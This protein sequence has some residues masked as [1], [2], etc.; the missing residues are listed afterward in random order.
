MRKIA[1]VL[2]SITL[3]SFS[4]GERISK[5]SVVKAKPIGNGYDITANIE[6]YYE[7]WMMGEV[8]FNIIISD[9]KRS[10]DIL[11]YKGNEYSIRSL[12]DIS[13]PKPDRLGGITWDILA[14]DNSIICSDSRKYFVSGNFSTIELSHIFPGK[15]KKEAIAIFKNGFHIGNIRITNLTWDKLGW[16]DVYNKTKN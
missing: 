12:G 2:L 10:G 6:I 4:G 11:Y 1:L 16:W 5:S 3:L 9:I 7:Y 8:T 13:I 14:S 15:S